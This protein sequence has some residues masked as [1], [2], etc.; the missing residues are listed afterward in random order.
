MAHQP[1]QWLAA[2][3]MP[4]AAN[5]ELIGSGPQRAAGGAA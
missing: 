4:C 1:R 5:T 2:M 3:P